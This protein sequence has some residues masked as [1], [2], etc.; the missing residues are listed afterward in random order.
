M[1]SATNQIIYMVSIKSLGVPYL[2]P[3][4]PFRIQ[5]L[6]DTIYRGDLQTLINSKHTYK[7]D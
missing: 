7:D 2:S 5:E 6:K 3:L 4:I 1:I